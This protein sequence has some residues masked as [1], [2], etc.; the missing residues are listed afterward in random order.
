MTS[1]GVRCRPL[2][3]LLLFATVATADVPDAFRTITAF[4]DRRER[5]AEQHGTG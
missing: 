1:L 5:C 2:A 3:A 4:E